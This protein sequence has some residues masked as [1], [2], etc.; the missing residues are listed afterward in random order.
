MGLFGRKKERRQQEEPS[1][2]QGGQAALTIYACRKDGGDIRAAAEAAFQ[3]VVPQGSAGGDRD[4]TL[5]LED[6]STLHFHVVDDFRETAPQAAGMKNFFSNAPLD[7]KAVK[8]AA[9]LQI[10]MFNCIVG[11]QFT[12]TSDEDRT[13]AIIDHVFR[14]A[15]KLAGF[16]LYPNMYLFRGD[17]KLLISMDG[18]T[19]LTEFRPMADARILD[20]VQP[21]TETDVARRERSIAVCRRKGIPT[22]E[23]LRAYVSDAQCVIP[24]KEAILLR[25]ICTFA[26]GVCSEVFREGG[27]QDP[28][29]FSDMMRSLEEQYGFRRSLSPKER[30]YL[31][32]PQGHDKKEHLLYDWRYEDCAVLLWALGLLE[33]GEPD[34]ACDVP[35]IAKLIWNH[36][37]ASL[38]DASN[39][40]TKDEIL[41]LQDL[42]LRYDWACVE[43][44][45]K[46]SRMELLDPSVVYEWHYALNWLTGA[47]GI[48]NW[49]EVR[50]DT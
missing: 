28:K 35:G 30:A 11:I 2:D 31:D 12:T 41:D 10:G 27:S 40:R 21:E 47:G 14:L 45:V 44:R 19:D 9:L 24:D 23:H 7:D 20:S 6:G 16:V 38:S 3:D 15:D 25:A 34:H 48:T 4:F 22:A 5:A 42:I 29:Q 8:E 49:D 32:D 46:G 1:R 13:N 18:K 37:L 50:P 33:I 26:T 43:A 39:L 17:G 36:D